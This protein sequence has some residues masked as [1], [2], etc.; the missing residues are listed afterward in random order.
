M[1]EVR[2]GHYGSPYVALGRIHGK[3]I[4]RVFLS[5]TTWKNLTFVIGQGV[6]EE[7][8]L[9]LN[10]WVLLA[11]INLNMDEW[12]D[13]TRNIQ[14]VNHAMKELRDSKPNLK[15]SLTKQSQGQEVKKQKVQEVDDSQSKE[16][17]QQKTNQQP[18]IKQYQWQIVHPYSRKVWC[19]DTHWVF[20]ETVAVERLEEY[21]E[22]GYEVPDTSSHI[23]ETREIPLPSPE[24]FVKW[25]YLYHLKKNIVRM[26]DENCQACEMDLCGQRD[27]MEGGCLGKWEDAVDSYFT[28]AKTNMTCNQIACAYKKVLSFLKVD[29]PNEPDLLSVAFIAS[30]SEYELIEDT[31]EEVKDSREDFYILFDEVCPQLSEYSPFNSKEEE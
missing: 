10:S 16:S 26:R 29:L 21:R 12:N 15:R 11:R 14:G 9:H 6:D 7:M 5:S 17:N 20:S 8:M 19:T 2:P 30:M 27:H 3:S 23:I 28:Q 13:L 22:K 18:I 1:V 31:K 24:H 4:E 25:L